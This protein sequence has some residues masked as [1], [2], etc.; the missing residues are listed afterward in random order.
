VPD[1][2]DFVYVVLLVGVAT[3]F[4]HYY[5]WPRL[6]SRAATGVPGARLWGYRR[7]IAGQW[8]FVAAG[9]LIWTWYHRSLSDLR[10]ATPT[11]WRLI[12]SAMLVGLMLALFLYQVMSVRRLSAE[13]RER[14]RPKLGKLGFI[15]PHTRT[16]YRW[17]LFLSVTAGI[18]EEFL[19]RGYLVWFLL[20]WLGITGAYL[21][22]VVLFGIGHSYQGASG[23]V[24]AT[25][26]GAVMTGIVALTGWLI[27]AMIVHALVDAGSGSV[28]YMILCNDGAPQ[29]RHLPSETVT[30]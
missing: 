14:V 30:T 9:G 7:G 19:F 16:E 17:F 11:G 29:E 27:P 6:R 3:L 10:L 13:R 25:L 23:A 26:A 2:I 12:V 24:R 18:C 1:P 4:E 8:G 20:P 15:L 22:V 5:F 28:A 21:G